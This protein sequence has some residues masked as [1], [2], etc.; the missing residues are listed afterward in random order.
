MRKIICFHLIGLLTF[1]VLLG[2]CGKQPEPELAVVTDN[3]ESSID[4][5]TQPDETVQDSHEEAISEMDL[6]DTN[7]ADENN[8]VL[9]ENTVTS[10][11]PISHYQWDYWV[12]FKMDYPSG[13]EVTSA[14]SAA[15]GMTEIIRLTN[16]RGVEVFYVYG[17]L[18]E[19]EDRFQTP[20][21]EGYDIEKID[22][23]DL[24]LDYLAKGF[25]VEASPYVL[26]RLT[27]TGTWR[28]G[29]EEQMDD[30]GNTM[31]AILPPSALGSAESRMMLIPCKNDITL[32][33]VSP[34]MIKVDEG[35]YVGCFARS[36]DGTFTEDEEKEVCAMLKSFREISKDWPGEG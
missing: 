23:T 10:D 7:T 5:V 13:W 33:L 6:A 21:Y 20:M 15:S 35:L 18:A 19:W 3:I 11:R 34:V 28:M 9:M 12:T 25:P 26:A 4:D 17:D 32:N 14:D 31:Y 36:S 16:D 2:A 30:G 1:A 24:T 8:A 22:D 29:V 27:S